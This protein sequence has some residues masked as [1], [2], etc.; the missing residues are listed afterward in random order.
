MKR[1]ATRAI[2]NH[3]PPEK[4]G[5]SIFITICRIYPPCETTIKLK[6][7]RAAR[8]SSS[9][10][11]SS[12]VEK[13]GQRAA[14]GELRKRRGHVRDHRRELDSGARSRSYTRWL[15]CSS[16]PPS[17]STSSLRTSMSARP[18]MSS[19]T[20]AAASASPCTW[21]ASRSRAL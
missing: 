11:D 17:T 13:N 2:T 12:D 14:C 19:S 15:P 9:R 18:S 5:D 7:I 4:T 10:Q 16:P 1:V 21:M 20:R 3:I 8:A 6:A